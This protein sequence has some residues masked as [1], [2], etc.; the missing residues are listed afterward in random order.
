MYH[1]DRGNCEG[2]PSC[3]HRMDGKTKGAKVQRSTCI[4]RPNCTTMYVMQLGFRVFFVEDDG[5]LRSI[6]WPTYV[7]LYFGFPT[8]R[9]PEYAGRAMRC[10]HVVIE[11]E[12]RVPIGLLETIFFIT[13]FNTDGGMDQ[14]KKV[15][16]QRLTMDIRALQSEEG[17]G[18]CVIDMKPRLSERRYDREFRWCPTREEAANFEQR[19]AKMLGL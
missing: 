15:E 1:L 7:G 2:K 10:V 3:S 16:R 13:H 14:D 4:L 18:E 8:V 9:F 11:M 6:P 17:P 5:C 19:I 12:D